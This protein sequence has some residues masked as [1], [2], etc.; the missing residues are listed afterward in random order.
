M[1]LKCTLLSNI[2]SHLHLVVGFIWLFLGIELSA[3]IGHG[4]S[5][6]TT[7]AHVTLTYNILRNQF[8]LSKCIRRTA[9]HKRYM[10]NFILLSHVILVTPSGPVY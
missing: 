5:T 9:S 10:V 7:C 2:Y 3:C 8:L 1:A 6:L 4:R